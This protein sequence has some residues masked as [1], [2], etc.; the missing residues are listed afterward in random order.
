MRFLLGKGGNP[1]DYNINRN[2][3]KRHSDALQP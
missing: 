1:D 3:Q 2:V